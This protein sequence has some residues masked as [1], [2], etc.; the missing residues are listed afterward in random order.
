MRGRRPA[1]VRLA[2]A[3]TGDL[4]TATPVAVGNKAAVRLPGRRGIS[5]TEWTAYSASGRELET[6]ND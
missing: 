5:P 4:V 6:G 3:L 1:M 2:Y